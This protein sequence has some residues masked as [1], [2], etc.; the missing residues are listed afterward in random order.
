MVCLLLYSIGLG[1]LRLEEWLDC[2]SPFASQIWIITWSYWGQTNGDFGWYKCDFKIIKSEGDSDS[3]MTLRWSTFSI[4]L[5]A[6][7]KL[8]CYI[9][10][11]GEKTKIFQL[12]FLWNNYL[13]FYYPQ[14]L[15]SLIN[16]SQLTHKLLSKFLTLDDFDA[17]FREANHNVLAPY[18]RICLHVFWELNYDFLPTYCYNAATNRQV[19]TNGINKENSISILE[20]LYWL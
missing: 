2:W 7:N 9:F 8:S 15:E 3:N 5:I 10:Y 6:Q 20:K 16:V 19:S 11:Y 1:N 13:C 18:G 14:E 4:R 17:M 12:F